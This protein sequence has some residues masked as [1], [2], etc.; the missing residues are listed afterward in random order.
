MAMKPAKDAG[1]TWLPARMPWISLLFREQDPLNVR[2]PR[3][4][5]ERHVFLT[6]YRMYGLPTNPV[7]DVMDAGLRDNFGRETAAA[8]H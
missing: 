4:A 1:D 3:L 2:L 6:C 7:I 5:D 8:A